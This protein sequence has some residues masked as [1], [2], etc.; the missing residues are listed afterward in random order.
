[1]S[2]LKTHFKERRQ[3]YIDMPM[4]DIH[5]EYFADPNALCLSELL[6]KINN[7]YVVQFARQLCTPFMRQVLKRK[8]IDI[9]LCICL[10]NYPI[11]IWEELLK[12]INEKNIKLLVKNL[13]VILE[14]S[15]KSTAMYVSL[16]SDHLNKFSELLSHANQQIRQFA[17]D[18]FAFASI[19]HKISK[20]LNKCSDALKA[21]IIAKCQSVKEAI[22]TKESPDSANEIDA[23]VPMPDVEDNEEDSTADPHQQYLS[24]LSSKYNALNQSAVNVPLPS[25]EELNDLKWK[26][27]FE[28]LSTFAEVL[29]KHINGEYFSLFISFDQLKSIH[30]SD[31][32]SINPTFTPIFNQS[33]HDLLLPLLD[34]KNVNVSAMAA[35]C[36]YFHLQMTLNLMNAQSI[37]QVSLGRL[38]DK[39][40]IHSD[41]VFLCSC[42]IKWDTCIDLY[43][44]YLH[45]KTPFIQLAMLA[46]IKRI[47]FQKSIPS[48]KSLIALLNTNM[49]HKDASIRDATCDL[50]GLIK[51]LCPQANLN[52]HDKLKTTKIDEALAVYTKD[53]PIWFNQGKSNKS[54]TAPKPQPPKSVAKPPMFKA[55]SS[56]S[57]SKSSTSVA[58]K[59]KLQQRTPQ[60]PNKSISSLAFPNPDFDDLTTEYLS[61]DIVKSIK[62]S[63]YKDRCAAIQQFPL[64]IPF[65]LQLH[66]L[67]HFYKS[68][69]NFNVILLLLDRILSNLVPNTNIA[70]FPLFI[71]FIHSHMSNP[72]CQSAISDILIKSIQLSDHSTI[73]AILVPLFLNTK[74]PKIHLIQSQFILISHEYST[75]NSLSTITPYITLLQNHPN[76]Q[77]KQMAKEMSLKFNQQ[78]PQKKIKSDQSTDNAA[79]DISAHIPQLITLF[80]DNNWK[81]R[82][83]AISQL[84]TLLSH[85]IIDNITPLYPILRQSLQDPNKNIIIAT[86]NV[87]KLFNQSS[88]LKQNHLIHQLLNCLMDTKQGIQLA[89]I[90][91][92]TSMYANYPFDPLSTLILNHAILNPNKPQ[93]CLLL[94][95]LFFLLLQSN[96]PTT[97]KPL[98][99]KYVNIQLNDK[100]VT[101]KQ[102]AV[103]LKEQLDSTQ[104]P[105]TQQVRQVQQTP[106]QTIPDPTT[107]P[108]SQLIPFLESLI[109]NNKSLDAPFEPLVQV[110]FDNDNLHLLYSLVPTS[111]LLHYLINLKDLKFLNIIKY[112]INKYSTRVLNEDQMVLDALVGVPDTAVAPV[113]QLSNKY[114]TSQYESNTSSSSTILMIHQLQE[115]DCTRSYYT[116]RQLMKL[117]HLSQLQ[118]Q[119][120][121]RIIMLNYHKHY[122]GAGGNENRL[123]MEI[124][125][126]FMQYYNE[127]GEEVGMVLRGLLFTLKQLNGKQVQSMMNNVII[128]ILQSHSVMDGYAILIKMMMEEIGHGNMENIMMTSKCM[129]KMTRREGELDKKKLLGMLDALMEVM[130]VHGMDYKNNNKSE[131]PF[132]TIKTILV[133]MNTG[134]GIL[135]MEMNEKF[136]EYLMSKEQSPTLGNEEEMKIPE[137]AM[138]TGGGFE[139]RLGE[140]QVKL[141]M[142]KEPGTPEEMVE[143]GRREMVGE[144]NDLSERLKR[145]KQ[146]Q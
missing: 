29:K 91:A 74:S 146:N 86:I 23:D 61:T 122:R 46:I 95:R 111:K 144:L 41:L 96:T 136:R 52:E 36:L 56:K 97:A 9:L 131:I 107:M 125:R 116:I 11:G 76:A 35:Q 24:T 143:T 84:S 1:M 19:H 25:D 6:N 85:P 117:S 108:I 113:V 81:Q 103:H 88:L 120:T 70:L 57:L 14:Y 142:L 20:Y 22:V 15:E 130:G 26:V 83:L 43:P 2:I 100:N 75:A 21:S 72:K 105:Q 123:L 78:A 133:H 18:L 66:L 67:L 87:F 45:H 104:V 101:N 141:K 30:P 54:K 27:K 48:Y 59:R 112:I 37:I 132:R 42:I 33:V 138:P 94:S 129:L 127:L 115:C 139:E 65:E 90:D 106:V 137:F 3:I 89:V 68:E 121:T 50:L 5:P 39:K 60:K 7:E 82:Q 71:P 110:L 17:A 63:N 16:Q 40:L 145:L 118:I 99:L 135:G 134:E 62:S 49:N 79:V 73:L 47:L 53:P 69:S 12:L 58:T 126:W 114:D 128:K 13:S 34:N 77:L 4:T 119:G 124:G 38:K 55:S 109:S 31:Y 10:D 64:E 98:F 102:Y 32:K 93:M 44:T 28:A 80:R 140:L 51:L 8:E 92:L